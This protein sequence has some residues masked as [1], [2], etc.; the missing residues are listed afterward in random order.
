MVETGPNPGGSVVWLHGLGADGHDFEPIVPHLGIQTP[1]RFVFPHAPVRPITLNGGMSMRAWYDIVDLNRNAA[2][3]ESGISLSSEQAIALMSNEFSKGIPWEKIVLAGFSQGGAIALYTLPRL[4]HKLAGVMA[5]SSYMPVPQKFQQERLPTND[6]TP[7]FM[8]HGQMDQ[9][10]PH[11]MGK[12]SYDLL[13]AAGYSVSWYS[14]PM[15]HNVS[16]EE[17]VDIREWLARVFCE[18]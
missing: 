8:A 16:P 17:I 9:V 4:N 10:L 1:L 14:Y 3:D 2:Q 18:D 7:V 13:V 5:L 6:S 11:E 12:E 15:A